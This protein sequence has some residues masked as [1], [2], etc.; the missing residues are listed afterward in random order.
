MLEKYGY[1]PCDVIK[2]ESVSRLL[3]GSYDDWCA[4]R[5]AAKLGREEDAD[6]FRRRAQCWTNVFDSSL[7]LV[8]GRR[9]DGSWRTPYDPLA[10]G[11]GAETENDFTEGNAWQYTWHV[12]QDPEGLVRA[13]G[14]VESAVARLDRMF[15]QETKLVGGGKRHDITGVIG[16]YVHGNEPSHHVPYFYQYLRRPGRVAEVV[17]DVF[18]RL[19]LPKPDGLCGNDDCGQMSAWYVFSAMGFY[20][21]NP[22]SGEY[23]I[24]APQVGKVTLHLENGKVFSV[25]SKSLSRE[26]KYVKTVTLNGVPLAGWKIRH[27]DVMAGGE[28]VFEMTDRSCR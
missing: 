12:L 28:L 27:A 13:M 2:G 10:L 14:G 20:P 1:Y 7:G 3:E 4:A 9:S 17:R 16:Q 25:V 5:L 21:F 11:H 24:G 19:Y 26:N 8:R 18:D 22:C 23:V 15:I 6:F